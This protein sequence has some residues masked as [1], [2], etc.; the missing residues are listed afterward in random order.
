MIVDDEARFRSAGLAD[1]PDQGAV[2]RNAA[3][4]LGLAEVGGELCSFFQGGI[5]E[6][7]AADDH[8][9][10]RNVFGVQPGIVC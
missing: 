4:L 5:A 2:Y 7:L 10:T 3:R 8:M 1:M 6:F 9:R